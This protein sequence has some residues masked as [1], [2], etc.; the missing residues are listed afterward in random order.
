MQKL[1]TSVLDV[2]TMGEDL[3]FSIYD[4]YG[5]VDVYQLTPPE[6]VAERIQDSDIV[7]VNKIKLNEGNL[8]DAKNVK[9]ICV[10]AT[11]FDN[12]DVEYCKRAGI[13][14]CNVKGYSTDSV[15]QVTAALALSLINK[16][17]EYDRYVKNLSY[18][19]S[20]VQICS[21]PVF[22]EMTGMTWGIVGLGNIGKK[23][24]ETAKVFGCK[25]IAYKRTPD[26]NYNCVSL[27]ELCKRSDII[28]LHVPL[29]DGTKQLINDKM[30][31]LMKK[32]CI[33][34]NAAR[35]AVV[36]E[37]AV[38]NA[39]IEGR[40]G[41]LAVDVFSTEPLEEASP[42]TRLFDYQNVILTPHMAWGA[43]EARVRC[44]EEIAL[45]IDAFLNGEKR[46]RVDI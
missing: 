3:E 1:K 27:E 8:K 22:H 15:A 45:N 4:K 10:T 37:E 12:I 11:G 17:P 36:D 40:I 16:L 34:I 5:E 28:S 30:L 18:T 42:Y 14:V 35:G 21:K 24:A 41:G 19:N 32:S 7:I 13:A 23:V 39:V 6:R 29:N 44:L 31:S 46:N 33:L 2:A 9:I 43:Y 25:V 26:E 38:T 20:N